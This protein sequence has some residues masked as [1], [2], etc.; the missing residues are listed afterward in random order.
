[1]IFIPLVFSSLRKNN[2]KDVLIIKNE[3]QEKGIEKSDIVKWINIIDDKVDSMEISNGTGIIIVNEK[4]KIFDIEKSSD[5]EIV[6]MIRNDD[7]KYVLR[8]NKEE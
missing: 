4:N 2:D 6:S 5:F 1:M 7:N 8:I 3:I